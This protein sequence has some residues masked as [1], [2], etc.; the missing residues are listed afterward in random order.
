MARPG[1]AEPVRGYFA[2]T[3]L[4]YTTELIPLNSAT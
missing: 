2:A 1:P 3:A 4:I